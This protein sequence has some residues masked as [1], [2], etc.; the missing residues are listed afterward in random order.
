MFACMHGHNVH[1]QVHLHVSAEFDIAG[2]TLKFSSHYHIRNCQEPGTQQEV[3]IN[4]LQLKQTD[5][6]HAL[7][8]AKNNLVLNNNKIQSKRACQ[9]LLILH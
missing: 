1:V 4:K 5:T 7:Y 9:I 6:L 8:Y 2:G 3:K